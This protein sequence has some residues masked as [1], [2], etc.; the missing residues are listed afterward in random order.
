VSTTPFPGGL[1]LVHGPENTG[2]TALLVKTVRQAHQNKYGTWVATETWQQFVDVV[3]DSL[4]MLDDE[5]RPGG[6]LRLIDEQ[7]GHL[8]PE[9]PHTNWRPLVLVFDDGDAQELFTGGNLDILTRIALTGQGKQVAAWISL[10][11]MPGPDLMNE[12]LR[13]ALASVTATPVRG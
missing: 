13:N 9:P 2:K 5:H 7:M 4:E 12:T 11:E 6:I 10:P 8:R 3:P 1:H